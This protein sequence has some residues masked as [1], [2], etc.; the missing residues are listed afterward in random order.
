MVENQESGWDADGRLVE[1]A[2]AGVTGEGF[3]G[4]FAGTWAAE[5]V[6]VA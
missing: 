1:A 2:G 6:D 5:T 4:M 3:E